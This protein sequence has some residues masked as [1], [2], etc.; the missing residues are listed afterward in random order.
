MYPSV[1]RNVNVVGFFVELKVYVQHLKRGWNQ[2]AIQTW[3]PERSPIFFSFPLHLIAIPN[4]NPNSNSKED[5][6]VRFNVSC[7]ENS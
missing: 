6:L 5:Y 4:R 2:F 3:N 7:I 1:G